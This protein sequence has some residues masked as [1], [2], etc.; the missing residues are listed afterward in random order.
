[1]LDSLKKI[2]IGSD[3]AG[4]ILK[5]YL[6]EY[7]QKEQYSVTDFGTF[8]EESMDY[9][10]PVHPL[11][12]AVN[13]IEFEWGVIIC[14][15]GNGVAM[16]ANKYPKVRAAVCWSREIVKLARQHNDANIISLPARF[17][18]REQ[19]IEFLQLFLTTD[20]EGGRHQRRV[21][22]ISQIL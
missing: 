8:S 17:I 1:M 12:L 16:V 6:K 18:S 15:S 19:A 3:H 11:A 2:A 5:E 14:G 22:K 13:N 20:F 21:E 9:P 7:L 10:D 4:F